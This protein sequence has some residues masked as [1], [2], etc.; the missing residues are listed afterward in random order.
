M[1]APPTKGYAR[2]GGDRELCQSRLSATPLPATMVRVRAKLS[3]PFPFWDP[4]PWVALFLI[5]LGVRLWMVD[6]LGSSLPILD[7]WNGQ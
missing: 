5:V 2:A 1:S 7:E 6:A 3:E 4:F